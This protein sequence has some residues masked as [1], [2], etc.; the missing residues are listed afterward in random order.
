VVVIFIMRQFLNWLKERL[1][2]KRLSKMNFDGKCWEKKWLW[3]PG[4]E[5]AFW[6]QLEGN[7]SWRLYSIFTTGLV[8]FTIPY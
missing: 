3:S 7:V 8:E 2:F 5:F 1:Q 4:N 6:N